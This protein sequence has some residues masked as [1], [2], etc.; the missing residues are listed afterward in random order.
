M[1]KT[2]DL[3]KLRNFGEIPEILGVESTPKGRPKD[4]F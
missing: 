3:Q 2:S 1:I 4:K